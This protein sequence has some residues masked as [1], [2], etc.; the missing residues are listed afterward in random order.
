MPSQSP[1]DLVFNAQK[2]DEA[3]NSDA[4]TFTDRLGNVRR[5]IPALERQFPDAEANMNA[6]A[7]DRLAVAADRV[8]TEG[9]R[10]RAVD[11]AQVAITQGNPYPTAANIAAG[12][13]ATNPTTNKFFK[14]F[15]GGAD[16]LKRTSIYENVAGLAVLRD[17]VF[18][19]DEFDSVFNSSALRFVALDPATGYIW[20]IGSDSVYPI[21][22]TVDGQ[23]EIDHATIGAS[24]PVM[25]QTA[26]LLL[27]MNALQGRFPAALGFKMLDPES[28]YFAAWG[29]DGV[30]PFRIRLDGTVE[31]DRAV[32]TDLVGIDINDIKPT[33]LGIQLQR[34]TLPYVT[35]VVQDPRPVVTRGR[36]SSIAVRTSANGSF[37][38]PMPATATPYIRGTNK[39]GVALQIRR[40]ARLPFVGKRYCG[41]FDPGAVAAVL[42][43]GNITTATTW[44]TS[45][46]F[47]VGDF[48]TYR[49][50]VS[51]VIEGYTL[52][53]SDALVWDGA[54]W[55]HQPA[56][57]PASGV[58]SGRTREA[59]DFW[60]VTRAGRYAGVVVAEGDYLLTIG[61]QSN[62]GVGLN[63]FRVAATGEGELFY[64][65]EFAPASGL[66]VSPMRGDVWQA[67]VAGTA[68]GFTFAVGDYAVFEVSAWVQVKSSDI[69]SVPAGSAVIL[70]TTGDA[71]DY[72]VR[73]ANKS[74]ARVGVTFDILVRTLVRRHIDSLHLNSDSMY[75]VSNLGARV[76]EKSG[77]AGTFISYGGA[78]SNE[79]LAMMEYEFRTLGDR[80]K[81]CLQSIWQGTNNLPSVAD[82]T[83]MAQIRETALRARQLVGVRDGGLYHKL[84][85]GPRNLTWNGA[86][87]VASMHEGLFNRNG[88]LFSLEQWYDQVFPSE[89]YSPYRALLAAA[90]S[91]TLPDP[92]FPGM[93]EAQVA[94]TYGIL[95]WS[96]YMQA[97]ALAIPQSSL[98][99]VGDWTSADLPT[100]GQHGDYYRRTGGGVIGLL[101][102]NNAGV[103]TTLSSTDATHMSPSGADA[104]STGE[105][106]FINT[107]YF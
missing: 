68:S 55:V 56:P 23:V 85:P 81:G 27:Q 14:V 49:G 62:S 93:T 41:E 26:S 33:Q 40:S 92:T 10:D 58:S 54:A 80:Y 6:T 17:E 83:N 37:W 61:Y 45:G 42:E 70:P 4:D 20:G 13:A 15:R 82:D 95:P 47:V 71:S 38:E 39:S 96:F 5:T 31:I 72:E 22:M 52:N 43:R 99:H 105:V 16:G 107:R 91:S 100:G 87:M 50:E 34:Q 77:R 51:R 69:T 98:V 63:R 24:S 79:V 1:D 65:G 32:I 90:A 97:T 59:G 84:P 12:V 74:G 66:P 35:H 86:R 48:Y 76:I 2:L 36:A 46:T 102:Y 89:W 88:S 104:D 28:G 75:G 78:R 8:V 53:T 18:S 7:V 101:I 21:R 57:T 67:S 64:R 11:A 29:S 73:Q 60:R 94:A 3:L 9:A 44:P 30:Y 25:Q 106:S 103:W 19:G